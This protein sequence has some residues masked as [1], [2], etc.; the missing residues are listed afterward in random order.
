MANR[1][2]CPCKVAAVP[3]LG[4]QIRTR[5]PPVACQE[6]YHYTTTALTNQFTSRRKYSISVPIN[7]LHNIG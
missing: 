1:Y 5:F 6:S 4:Y 3:R 7:R 2:N